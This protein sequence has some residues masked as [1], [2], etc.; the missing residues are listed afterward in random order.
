ML[1]DERV[2][3]PL[4]GAQ[5]LS[6]AL[7]ELDSD[8]RKNVDK[9]IEEDPNL[10][11]ELEEIRAHIKVHQSV[12]SVAPRRGTFERLQLRMKRDR[13][14]E[15]AIPGV[16]RMLRRAF[17]VAM[18]VG[19]IAVILLVAFSKPPVS[20][21]TPDVIGQIVYTSP[22][23][24]VGE[25]R[26]EVDRAEL[27]LHRE[28]STGAYDA[29]LWLPTGVA[30]TYSALEAIQN[31][32][33]RFVAPRRIELTRGT[34]RRIEGRPGGIG[35]GPFVIQTPH[36]VV[37]VE[38]ANLSVGIARDGSETQVSV[39]TGSARVFGA[40]SDRSFMVSAGQ[41]TAIERGRLPNPP[42]Q[43]L[44]LRL[45][46]SP[47][48]Q[49]VIEATMVNNG[50]VPVKVR[51]PIDRDRAFQE[52][53]YVLHVAHASEFREG[54]MPENTTLPPWPVTPEPDPAQDHAGEEWIEPGQFYRFSF[55][56]S[57]V[58]VSTPPVEHWLRLEYRG[59]LYGPAG[60]AR[61][62]VQSEHLKVDR[63]RR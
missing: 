21:A 27:L 28:Y 53:V 44:D 57:S 7:G 14:V 63:R 46:M 50:Y 61:V 10:R 32:E 16:H 26:D 24:T 2:T 47:A 19:L 37:Q 58:F 40:D 29:F 11:E 25:R 4:P 36:A 9:R 52:P 35:E 31:T 30:N 20:I 51:R 56:V 59:D 22:T 42:M 3:Q 49:S 48:S 54:I 1:D 18:I 5:L 62:R 38:E 34:L 41:C 39:L 23:L 17:G 45:S 15:G 55:D 12:R 13:I 8:S 60:H 43:M 33:F 6:Y